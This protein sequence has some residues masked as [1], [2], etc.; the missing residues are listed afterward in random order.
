VKFLLN[1]LAVA[2]LVWAGDHATPPVA[3]ALVAAV[4]L[5]LGLA[6][7]AMARRGAV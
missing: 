7:V 5:A 4:F 6:L 2:A 3:A 1:L